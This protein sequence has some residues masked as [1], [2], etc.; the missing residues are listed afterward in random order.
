MKTIFDQSVVTVATEKLRKSELLG[1]IYLV[2]ENYDVIKNN[3]KEFGLLTPLLVDENYF[4]ISGNLRL[5]IAIDLK[6][7]QVPVVFVN[8]PSEK[9]DVIALSTNQFRKKSCLEDITEIDFC[10]K[11]YSIKT[12]QRTDINPELKLAKEEK[13]LAYKELGTYKVRKLKS[14][15]AL[16]VKLYGD[17][18]AKVEELLLK[19]DKGA[20]TLNKVEERL[21][22]EIIK[23]TNDEVVPKV[24]DFITEK[25][26]IYNHTCEVMYELEN[27]SI[28][29]I[30]V[31]PTYFGMFDYGTGKTQLGFEKDVEEFVDKLVSIF[32]EAYRVLK[33]DGSLFVN[34]ND[35]VRER[36]YQCVPELFLIKMIDDL[37]KIASYNR[38]LSYNLRYSSEMS[39][40]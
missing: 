19:V 14:I 39:I 22:N 3:I 16:G 2:P 31:S 7:E 28:N 18:S 17:D 32:K 27:N 38:N 8:T 29:T 35:C 12:G 25:V 15:Q 37:I 26:K 20:L 13:D 40:K 24:Y 6:M 34:L 30:V 1:S 11:Y 9:R 33:E 36:Q 5:Q 21:N 10:E 4:V 23:K